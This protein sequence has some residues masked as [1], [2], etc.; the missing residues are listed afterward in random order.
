M[1]D[2][3]WMKTAYIYFFEIY[4]V[5]YMKSNMQEQ[6]QKLIHTNLPIDIYIFILLFVNFLHYGW[7]IFI[8][9]A[10]HLQKQP[11]WKLQYKIDF[12]VY[13]ISCKSLLIKL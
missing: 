1:S 12:I 10:Q 5:F 6:S 7:R 4:I 11:R 8:W 3:Y 2:I 9:Y 13:Q